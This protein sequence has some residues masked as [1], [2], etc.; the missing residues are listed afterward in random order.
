MDVVREFI[1]QNEK[2]YFYYFLIYKLKVFYH[3]QSI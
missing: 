2:Q 1:I 3:E